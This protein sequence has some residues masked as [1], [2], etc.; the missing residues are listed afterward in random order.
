MS[1][2]IK[3]SEILFFVFLT[4][5]VFE[6]RFSYL[7][8]IASTWVYFCVLILFLFGF[9]FILTMQSYDILAY[10]IFVIFHILKTFPPPFP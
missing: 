1:T 2:G 6:A 4:V 3:K 7:V 8:T 10:P 9:T 5:S